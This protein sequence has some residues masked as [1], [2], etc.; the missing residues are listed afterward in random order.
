MSS[1]FRC[2]ILL[3]SLCLLSEFLKE[4][5]AT[6]IQRLTKR[7]QY[8]AFLYDAW[9]KRGTPDFTWKWL[10]IVDGHEIIAIPR[11]EVEESGSLSKRGAY[12]DLPW[13]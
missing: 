4:G 1:V 2:Q 3:L 5:T 12:L 11:P 13:G 10:G 7:R 9:G 8:P 6:E